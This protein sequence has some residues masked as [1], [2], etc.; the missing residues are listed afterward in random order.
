MVS[1]VFGGVSRVE[2]H[3]RVPTVHRIGFVKFCRYILAMIR[4]D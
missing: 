1:E 3:F 4:D 2:E